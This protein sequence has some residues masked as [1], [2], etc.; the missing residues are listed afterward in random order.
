MPAD[1]DLFDMTMDQRGAICKALGETLAEQL[2]VAFALVHGSFVTDGPFHDIDIAAYFVGRDPSGISRRAYSLG[3]LLGNTL[4]GGHGIRP[5]PPIDLR[6]LNA[7][8]LGFCYQVLRQ[9]RLLANRDDVLRT[10]WTVAI[11]SR[12]LDIKPLY[13]MALKEAMTSWPSI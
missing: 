6:A 10:E 1:D 7:A 11:V 5:C 9:G 2:D 3:E 8:P 4:E 12:Y 13:E